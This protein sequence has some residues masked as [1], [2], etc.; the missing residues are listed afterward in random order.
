MFETRVTGPDD[1][2][3]P[4]RDG[5]DRSA[6]PLDGPAGRQAI[7]LDRVTAPLRPRLATLALICLGVLTGCAF[8]PPSDDNGGGPPNLPRPTPSTAGDAQVDTVVE[9]IARDLAVPWAIGFL[10]DGAALVTE[11]DSHR[12]LRVGPAVGPSGLVVVPVQTVPGVRTGGD[13]G[14][15]GLVV[16]PTYATDQTV[17][18]YYSTATDNRIARLTLGGTP[19]P[20]LTGI[21]TGGTHN[22][23]Q[24]GFGPDGYLYA[25]T[26][27]AGDPATAQLPTSL[28]GKVLRMTVTGRPAP[29]NP[30]PKSVIWSTGYADVAGFAWDDRGRLLATES[31][32]PTWD[33][34]DVVQAGH[35]FGWPVVEG[36][37]GRAGFIDPVAQ[38]SAGDG[39]CAGTAIV[40]DLLVTACLRGTRLWLVRLT[41][42]GTV[43]GAPLAALV[44][45]YGRLRAAAIAPDGSLWVGTSNRDGHGQVQ[46]GD[47]RILRVVVAGAGGAGR[48]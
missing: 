15:L 25:S 30:N 32:Q 40:G 13:A 22:G 19:Q 44:G 10:P 7:T 41:G 27:D 26:G 11:R 3:D 37:T 17:F 9:V 46:S 42:S 23:G 1:P 5:M 12:I 38:W 16:S 29:G 43:L 39:T 45:T 6:A 14:L 8:G 21:P 33:E 36:R 48:A 20:I 24:L 34:V 28:A 31:G 4:A 47:D 2:G 18:I 35:N